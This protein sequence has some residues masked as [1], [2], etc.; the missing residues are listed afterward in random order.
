MKYNREN[1]IFEYSVKKKKNKEFKA[2][3][4]QRVL[5]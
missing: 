3:L 5:I 1:T 2:F 4:N